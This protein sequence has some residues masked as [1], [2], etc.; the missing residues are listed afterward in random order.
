MTQT[1]RSLSTVFSET[2]PNAINAQSV[3]HFLK[4]EQ[5]KIEVGQ[6]QWVLHN[7]GQ[8]SLAKD[9]DET[10]VRRHLDLLG[11]Q[12]NQFNQMPPSTKKLD[13]HIT[14]EMEI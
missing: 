14:W 7:S 2:A 4:G 8:F 3:Q 9:Q 10:L 12:F 5:G 1:L 11:K 6:G 13:R